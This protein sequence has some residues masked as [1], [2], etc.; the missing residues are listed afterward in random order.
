MTPRMEV[1]S[2]P[3]ARGFPRT[4]TLGTSCKP[5]NERWM[6]L[7]LILVLRR[8]FPSGF[9][10]LRRRVVSDVRRA[11]AS[12]VLACLGCPAVAGHL[13][14]SILHRLLPRL[15][16]RCLTTPAPRR[17]RCPCSNPVDESAAWFD[18]ERRHGRR[19]L[20]QAKHDWWPGDFVHDN[21]R[22]LAC[23]S[24]LPA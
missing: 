16:W 9:F 14:L 12:E 10:S 7:G 18:G 13:I 11:F 15:P 24:S 21:V 5:S 3:L 23:N 6:G 20:L 17:S 19:V 2:L 22:S 4:A 1:P 8:R